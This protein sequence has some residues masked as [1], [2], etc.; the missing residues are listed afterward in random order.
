[1]K[2]LQK[3]KKLKDCTP[4]FYR[5]DKEEEEKAIHNLIKANPSIE[6]ID[7]INGQLK[8]L[9][10]LRSPNKIFTNQE[11]EKKVQK[12]I[13]DT[14]IEKYGIWVYYTWINKLVHI[15]D[16]KEF[17]EVRTNRNKNKITEEEQLILKSKKIGIIGLS[18]GN[19]I[20][21][22]IAM[23]RVCGELVLAD[24]D[25]IEL[26]NL[27][28]IKTGI[29]NFGLKKTIVVAREI[30]EID[31]FFK[32][33]CL[34][35]GITEKNVNQFF[36]KDGKLDICIEVCDGL[37]A[38]I[39][40]REKAK[41]FQIP[42]V[43][44]SSDRGTTDIERFDLNPNLPLLHGMIDHLDLDALKKAK[45]NEEKIPFL[46]AMLGPKTSSKR[47]MDSMLEIKKSITTWPQLASGVTFGGG[48]C[49]DVCRRILLKE[50]TKSGRY[51]V[52]VE[53]QISDN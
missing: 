23:E 49:T 13:K 3:T 44:N 35:D 29:Q 41:E 20:A 37:F 6:I 31:P 21:T 22:N 48:I 45:T 28:R 7:E 42:V 18:V 33:T 30:A 12:H 14:P 25:C 16:E 1:M 4:I 50:F 5:I 19:A 51:F 34:H 36:T 46:L 39:F 27:N 40:A 17:I 9:I 2:I 24:F 10:Q 43:M 8:E 53:E 26:S 38:K 47:L 15:L 32:V 11:L 52:D